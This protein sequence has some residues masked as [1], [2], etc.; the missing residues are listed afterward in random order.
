ML[1]NKPIISPEIAER[2]FEV[3]TENLRLLWG[4]RS[5]MPDHITCSTLLNIAYMQADV[6]L[7]LLQEVEGLK[8]ASPNAR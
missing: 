5:R 4:S 7:Y 6:I 3:I 1:E 2:R 8:N